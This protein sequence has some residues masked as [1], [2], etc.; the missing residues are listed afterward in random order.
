M[1]LDKAISNV[2]DAESDLA[3]QL[4]AI[5]ER[6]A[7]EHDLYHLG[8]TLARQ[9]ADHLTSLAPFSE[10]YGTSP[11]TAG[12][13]APADPSPQELTAHRTL[14]GIRTAPAPGPAHPLHKRPG[15]GDRL[16]HP[17]PGRPGRTR[18]RA[19]PSHEPVPPGYGNLR[20]V[21]PDADQGNRNTGPR[22]RPPDWEVTGRLDRPRHSSH[23]Q[24]RGRARSLVMG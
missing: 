21:A 6:H 15:S 2:Q 5:G 19:T 23:P 10:R 8:H 9:C 11:R 3:R 1:K 17:H 24:I 22:H 13:S 20:K 12:R 16:G 7:T 14:R 4:Q 18:P